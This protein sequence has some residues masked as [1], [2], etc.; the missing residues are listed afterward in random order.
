MRR[1]IVF[2]TAVVA[3]VALLSAPAAAHRDPFDPVIDPNAPT[4]TGTTGTTTT[5]TTGTGTA[6]EI[7]SDGLA[8]TGSDPGPW[9]VVAYALLALGAGALTAVKLN[10][11]RPARR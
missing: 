1:T 10:A 8:P 4:I 5:T 11:P 6:P 7:R 2:V 3:C 9:L